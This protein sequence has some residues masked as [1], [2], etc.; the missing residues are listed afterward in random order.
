MHHALDRR[1][2]GEPGQRED[3]RG[4]AAGGQRARQGTGLGRAAQ[5]QHPAHHPGRPA[6]D[7]ALP[8]DHQHL[9]RDRPARPPP[10]PTAAARRPPDRP[11]ETRRPPPA[12]ASGW[13]C[14]PPAIAVGQRLRRAMPRRKPG[15]QRL[16]ESRS[17]PSAGRDAPAP[18]W[19]AWRSRR[20]AVS[21][22]TGCRRRYFSVPPAKSPMSSSAISGR[23]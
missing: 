16:V 20:P 19:R 2:V 7:P 6:D 4:P 22:G 13:P 18:A 21:R 9:E 8:I 14:W 17:A 12:P 10:R 11:A 23:P 3:R 5:D 15:E 1:R